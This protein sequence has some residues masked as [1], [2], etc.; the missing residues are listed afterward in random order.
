M[1][2]AFVGVSISV[3]GPDDEL[4]IG[5]LAT[6]DAIENATEWLPT[7]AAKFEGHPIVER[8]IDPYLAY[9]DNLGNFG[10]FRPGLTP[11]YIHLTPV[12]VDVVAPASGAFPME[13]EYIRTL[14]GP[15]YDPVTVFIEHDG[16]QRSFGYS[17]GGATTTVE[18]KVGLNR[19]LMWAALSP[20]YAGPP[21]DVLR[22]D[23]LTFAAAPITSPPARTLRRGA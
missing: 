18:L 2:G 16:V 14:E 6:Y 4:R 11:F 9:P 10:T 5:N 20:T 12:E 13:G 21:I 7:L 1:I 22:V 17:P 8:V 3:A 23:T 19:L 15:H